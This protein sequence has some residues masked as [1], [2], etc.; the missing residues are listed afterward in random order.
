MGADTK[1]NFV[2]WFERQAGLLERLQRRVALEAL[3]NRGSFFGTELVP[4]ET[5]GVGSEVVGESCQWALTQ[6]RTLGLAA[7]RACATMV[8]QRESRLRSLC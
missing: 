3:C 7:N 6:W 5:A 8:P 1:A 4:M 2:S